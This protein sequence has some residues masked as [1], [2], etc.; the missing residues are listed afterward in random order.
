MTADV[1]VV[2]DELPV[3]T[4]EAE[5]LRSAGYAVLE[6]ADGLEA[7]EILRSEVVGAV[8]L[9]MGMPRCDGM[10]FLAALDDP[11]PTVIVSARTLADTDLENVAG[12]VD[13]V[14]TKPV[15]P[16]RLIEQVRAVLQGGYG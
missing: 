6:A 1:L 15:P 16:W 13:A 12:K 7:L 14:L 11:P 3:R 10:C 5:V 4:S 9:D 2:D 8:V